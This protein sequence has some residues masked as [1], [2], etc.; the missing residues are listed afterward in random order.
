MD[1]SPSSSLHTG[2]YSCKNHYVVVRVMSRRTEHGGSQA[3]DHTLAINLTNGLRPASDMIR[4]YGLGR[5]TTHS[6][7]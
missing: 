6:L 7:A 2:P 5:P 4:P 3:W 1:A